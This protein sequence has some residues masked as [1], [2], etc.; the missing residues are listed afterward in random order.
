MPGEQGVDDARNHRAVVAE[1]AGKQRLAWPAACACRLSR[2]SGLT[3]SCERQPRGLRG[4]AQSLG[5]S[6]PVSHALRR[7][8]QEALG[9]DRRRQPVP[10]AVIA[11][12]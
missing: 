11:C 10:A 1:N 8:G 7:S 5:P 12:R 2:I 9:V 6:P 3:R 4:V